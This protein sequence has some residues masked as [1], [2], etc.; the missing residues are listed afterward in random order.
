MSSSARRRY[1]RFGGTDGERAADLNRLADP[2]RRL[3][4]IVLAVRGGYGAARI[5]H[6]LDYE[7]L[8][9]RLTDQP[10]ALVGHSDFTAIQLRAVCTRRRQEFRRPHAH[11]RFRRRRSSAR[12]RCSTSG[13]AL[14]KPS[15]TVTSHVPQAAV[16]RR[17]RHVVGRQS[18][19]DGVADRHAVHAAGGGRDSVSRRRERASVSHRADDL[20]V[21][22]VGDSRGGSRRSCWANSPAE[23]HRTTTTATPS[24]RCSNRCRSVIRD[25]RR[26]GTAIRTCSGSADAAVRRDRA[27]GRRA[28]GFKHEALGLYPYLA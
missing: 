20:S 10:I 12:S 23:S 8:Q 19:D 13:A 5:L 14:T 21:A 7:G 15:F 25:S 2:S 28:G 3:P 27:S 1:Q 17:D 24:T 11:G 16:R 4:D 26:D 18:G 9:R 22:S 6:G